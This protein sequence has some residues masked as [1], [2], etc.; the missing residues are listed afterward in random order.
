MSLKHI[1]VHV[2]G[3]DACERRLGSAIGLAARFGALL[4]GFFAENDPRVMTVAL[5]D[6]EDALAPRVAGAEA[7]FRAHAEA[8]G[9][10]HEWLAATTVSDAAL[11]RQA[12]YAVQGC[13]LAVFGQPDPARTDIRAPAD[14]A[15]QVVLHAGRPLLIVPHA[16]QFRNVGRRVMVAWNSGREATRALNDALPL[17][18][19]A[20]H[21]TVVAINVE[22]RGKPQPGLPFTHILR[23]LQA[24]GV[25]AETDRMLVEDIGA[26]D[27]LLGRLTDDAIDLLV[28]G[29]HGHYGFP[30]MHRG[31]ST[32]HILRQMT[33]P[34]LMSH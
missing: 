14:L 26:M 6:A 10:E 21:V 2:D 3:S 19:A 1:L 8:A 29:A 22:E 11:I 33:V 7:L 30:F 34:V 5:M 24:H 15:E 4:T 31:G 23:H 18:R 25:R 28:M 12:V 17:L 13:D 9:L 16:G 32:R 27:M 20:E